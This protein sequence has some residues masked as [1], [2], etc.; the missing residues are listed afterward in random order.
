MICSVCRSKIL[1]ER[2]NRHQQMIT[3]VF[4]KTLDHWA[5]SIRGRPLGGRNEKVE[6]LQQR[7]GF[8]HEFAWLNAVSKD[9]L[10]AVLGTVPC[11]LS[12]IVSP[13]T[14]AGISILRGDDRPHFRGQTSATA[15]PLLMADPYQWTTASISQVVD[16]S[17]GLLPGHDDPSGNRRPWRKAPLAVDAEVIH[18]VLG[19][20]HGTALL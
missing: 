3:D 20:P 11:C 5:G 16:L 7:L 6:I 8:F 9:D 2:K 1:I 17:V 15:D 19:V 14:A 10:P 4:K 13:E 12:Q 18:V